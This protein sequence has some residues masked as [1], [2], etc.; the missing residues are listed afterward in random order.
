M[1]Y[2]SKSKYCLVWQCPK[3][4]WLSINKPELKT[5]D[6]SLNARFEEGNRIGDMAMPLFGDF[7]EVTTFKDD[8][9]LDLDRMRAL[10]RECI[11]NGVENICEASFNYNG[12]YCAV[13]I[14]RK[15]NDGYAIYEVK[16]STDASQIYAVDV[17]YQKYVLENCGVKVT[18]TYLICIDSDYVR[19]KELELDR[20]FKIIDLSDAVA[21]EIAD[22]PHLL[23]QAQKVCGMKDEPVVDLG[24]H[25]RDPYSCG[26]WEYCSAHLPTPNVFDIYRIGFKKA[27]KLYDSGNA[28][29]QDLL[30]NSCLTNQKQIRQIVHHFNDCG[31]EV[32]KDNVRAFLDTL[33]YPIYFLDFETVQ[34]VVPQFEGT[35]PF[36][37]IP[38][39]YSLH[40]IEY[41]G[42]PLLHKEFL[43]QSGAD[44]RRALAE[45]LCEDIPKDVCVT[46]YNRSFECTR[47]KELAE[48]FPDLAD[49]LLS[50]ESNIKDLWV[51][52]QKG[53]YYNRAMGG[54]FSIKSVLP[55]L[56]P[57]DPSLDYHNL[58]QIHNG[59]EAM[60]IFPKIK[61]MSPEEAEIARRNLLE[62]CKLDT[63]AMV[64]V[65]EKL[66][67]AVK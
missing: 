48:C 57:D 26:F 50:I 63:Y 12:L 35:K 25:C 45:R 58:D 37:Q 9:S 19:G 34:P 40:Y 33:S 38:F 5:A 51:P 66:K 13:D 32:D 61:D 21:A 62:Y 28:S 1:F 14:L 4:L 59:S 22:V 17:A 11:A 54:S 15:E 39:Q 55:A 42:G 52:F 23:D 6:P 60:S 41:E 47:L 43:A 20:F 3:L 65:W 56:F 30:S 49:H 16:S 31:D 8:G 53:Y 67:E 18:G 2:F 7:T 46:A 44:P 24:P 10:T 29:Y 27:L 36:A 64:K